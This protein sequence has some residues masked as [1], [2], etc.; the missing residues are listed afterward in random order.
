MAESN[1]VR[2]P[3]ALSPPASSIQLTDAQKAILQDIQKDF[4]EAVGGPDQNPSDPAY[5]DRWVTAVSESDDRLRSMIG[6]EGFNEWQI[7]NW[8]LALNPPGEVLVP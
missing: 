7:S 6:W 3:L 4:V 8:A 1:R 2:I 5:R